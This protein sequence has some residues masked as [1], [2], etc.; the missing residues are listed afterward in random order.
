LQE[1]VIYINTLM[2]AVGAAYTLKQDGHVRVDVFYGRLSDRGKGI[3]NILGTVI[4]LLPA[5]GYI[6]WV[7][8]DYVSV[9]WQIRE[10]SAE[11]SG[12]PYVYLLKFGILLL[13]GLLILQG[14]AELLRN[15]SILRR[16]R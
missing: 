15:I 13:C 12:L 4:L 8:W 16:D 2:V 6:A 3:V 7:S 1:S 10:R 5:M 11:N 14:V 9:S